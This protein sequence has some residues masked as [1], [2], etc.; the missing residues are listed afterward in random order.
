MTSLRDYYERCRNRLLSDSS[1]CPENRALFTDFFTFEEHKLKRI[2]ALEDLD[3]GCCKTLLGYTTRLRNVNLWFQNKPWKDL[4]KEDIQSVYDA[5]EEGRILTQSG[6]RFTDRHSYYN[7]IFKS[8]PFRLAGKEEVTR[9]VIEFS[10]KNPR[11]VRYATEEEF[12]RLVSVVRNPVALF[13][14]WLAWDIGENIH[15]L[16]QLTTREFMVQV[17][18]AGEREYLVSLPTSKLKR[19]RLTR[20]EITLHPET[21]KYADLVLPYTRPNEPVFKMG[22]R[23]AAKML[24]K[25]VR[26]SGAKTMPE[27]GKVRWKDLRSGMACYLLKHGWSRDEVNARLGHTPSSQTLNAYINFLALD[28]NGPKQ[29]MLERQKVTSGVTDKP[30]NSPTA[31]LSTQ[32]HGGLPTSAGVL[33]L[34]RRDSPGNAS[35]RVIPAPLPEHEIRPDADIAHMKAQI[36]ALRALLADVMASQCRRQLAEESGGSLQARQSSPA[37]RPSA[38]PHPAAESERPDPWR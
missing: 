13:L 21:V 29:R 14:L 20:S 36:D 16:L 34:D 28:R 7:K 30:V 9:E 17:S 31:L 12:R 18:S 5:L 32:P 22:Y 1:I 8:K 11:I 33:N 15:T 3:A 27:G 24:T 23:S 37:R 4:T 6:R 25:A 19:S 38:A 35:E 26:L 10:T 2:N